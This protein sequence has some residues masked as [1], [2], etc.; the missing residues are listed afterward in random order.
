MT[1]EN[2]QIPLG[3]LKKGLKRIGDA[4]AELALAMDKMTQKIKNSLES[5]ENK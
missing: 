2:R 3:D 5:E 1:E 4:F